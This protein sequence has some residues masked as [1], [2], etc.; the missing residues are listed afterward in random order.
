MLGVT[1]EGGTNAGS[2]RPLREPARQWVHL[3]AMRGGESVYLSGHFANCPACYCK[4][5]A[6]TS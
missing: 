5:P 1:V 4:R 3:C 6:A 2:K